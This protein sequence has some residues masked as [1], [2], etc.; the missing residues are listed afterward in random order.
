MVLKCFGMN[1]TRTVVLIHLMSTLN[2]I[3]I[4]NVLLIPFPPK[5]FFY[6]LWKAPTHGA[7][8]LCILQ[9]SA[10][11]NFSNG[12][13]RNWAVSESSFSLRKAA[14]VMLVSTWKKSSFQQ[15]LEP[16]DCE[17]G[18]WWG[19]LNLDGI[20][21]NKAAHGSCS[22]V[23]P[24]LTLKGMPSESANLKPLDKRKLRGSSEAFYWVNQTKC[25]LIYIFIVS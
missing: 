20:Y 10:Q 3:Y 15:L 25:N 9:W 11:H 16:E 18:D 1:V 5:S 22:A 7:F 14:K 2:Y 23:S 17:E 24:I 8:E 4:H 13:K 6:S 21:C 19:Y 12:C